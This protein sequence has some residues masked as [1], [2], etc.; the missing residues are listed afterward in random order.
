MCIDT[1]QGRIRKIRRLNM[2]K[3]LINDRYV[4]ACCHGCRDHLKEFKDKA[5]KKDILTRDKVKMINLHIPKEDNEQQLEE[6][7]NGGSWAKA[8]MDRVRRALIRCKQGKNTKPT[9]CL[10]PF[11]VW[12]NCTKQQGAVDEWT[13]QLRQDQRLGI[14]P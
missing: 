7:I 9:R 11:E 5:T 2:D 12:M 6:I 13:R 8:T 1:R 4:F 10:P 14:L 3:V